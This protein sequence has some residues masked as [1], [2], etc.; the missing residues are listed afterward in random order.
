VGLL[1]PAVAGAAVPDPDVLWWKFDEGT[2]AVAKDSSGKGHDGVIT[3]AAWK[4]GGVG[5]IG[6]CLDFPGSLAVRVEDKNAPSYLNGQGAIT[7]ALWIKS[8]VTNTDNGFIIAENPAGNDSFVT[9]RYD[10]AGAS[11]G[12][13]S[14]LK[15]AVTST[16]GGEQQLESAGGLQTTNWQHVVM[17]WKGGDLIQFY[18]DGKLITPTGRNGPNNAGTISGCTTLI[19]GLGGKDLSG[20]PGTG[21]NGLIDDVRVYS[22]VLTAAQIA[23]LAVNKPIAFK[24]SEPNPAN[25]AIGV[26]TPLLQWKKGDTAVFHNVYLGTTPDLTE[27]NLVGKNQPFTLYY[28]VA[29]LTP[30]A[31]YS[32]RVD[33]VEADMTTVRTGDVWSFI[34]QDVKAYYPTP[35][36]QSADVAPTGTLTWQAGQAAIKHHLYFGTSLDDVTNGTADTD[37]GELTDPTYTPTGLDR[38]TTYYWRVDELG[39]GGAVKAGAVWSFTT[40]LPVDDFESYTDDEGGRIYETWGDGW[41]NN[42]GSTVGNTTAPFAEQTIVRQGKQSMPLDYNNVN[43]PFYSEAEQEFTPVQNWTVGEVA[44]LR[45]DFR[46]VATNGTGALYVVVE[47]SVGQTA[48]VTNSDPAAVTLTTW[49]EWKI[50]LSSLTGVNPAKV[51]K[52]YI[53]V[54]DRQNPAKGGAGRIYI[55]DIRLTKP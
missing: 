34:A 33:E 36:D 55:D 29:G 43:S 50:P 20:N 16:P 23:E 6:Y 19:V 1:L 32:W 54:G 52:M 49:T 15:M 39:P 51:K 27:A 13:S 53:G 25:G 31:T 42:T 5:G 48:V 21:W 11:F 47:D 26:A 41:T 3:G 24:A 7:V 4:S 28:A 46:G 37:K 30:G 38:V 40:Y 22:T 35:V 12:G 44:D 18:A 8:R 10:A 14:I 2:G 17:T 45:L 9:M